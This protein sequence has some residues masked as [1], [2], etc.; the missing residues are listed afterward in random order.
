MARRTGWLEGPVLVGE[1]ALVVATMSAAL[2]LA[3]GGGE[4]GVRAVIRATARSSLLFFLAAFTA[5]S[6]RR[7]WRAPATAWLLRNRRYLGLSMAVSHAV[8]LAAILILA[9][10][11]PEQAEIP[12]ATRIGGTLGY[13]FLAAMAAT[14]SDRAFAWLGRRRWRAL[15]WT[16]AWVLWA[17]FALSY[18]PEALAVPA[19]AP[20]ALLVLAAGALRV[21]VGLREGRAQRSASPSPSPVSSSGGQ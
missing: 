20:L 7:L 5:S 16:G 10:R 9:A 6:L 12:V 14:S 13:V 8:H 15:H 3:Q 2:W 17:I 21:G 1:S 19:Y 4:E 18:V 11:W